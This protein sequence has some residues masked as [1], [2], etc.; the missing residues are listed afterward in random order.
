[1][2]TLRLF[3]RARAMIKCVLQAAST[4]LN[5]TGEK[6]ALQKFSLQQFLF[7]FFSHGG[8]LECAQYSNFAI[9]SRPEPKEFNSIFCDDTYCDLLNANVAGFTKFWAMEQILTRIRACEQLQKFCD[10]EQACTR[11]SFASKSSRGQILRALG[12][13]LW[14]FDSP[15]IRTFSGSNRPKTK[16]AQPQLKK[17]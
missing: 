8:L 3:L 7:L 16:N 5:T 9:I 17:N 4:L 6:W 13:F 2:R 14:P 12:K 11:L 1:M 10:H 15:T